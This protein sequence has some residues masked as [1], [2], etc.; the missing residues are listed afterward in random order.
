LSKY[1]GV[2]SPEVL[3]DFCREGGVT[4]VQNAVLLKASHVTPDAVD[5]SVEPEAPPVLLLAAEVVDEHEDPEVVLQ[6]HVIESVRRICAD[7]FL[8][9]RPV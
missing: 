9:V 8:L 7:V 6:S 5:D 1:R 3:P 4:V 2:G